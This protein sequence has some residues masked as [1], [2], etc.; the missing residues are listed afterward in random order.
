[1]ENQK[2]AK[3]KNLEDRLQNFFERAVTLCKKVPP[4]AL[5]QRIVSQLI[6]SSGSVPANFAEAS[7]A[8]SKKDF[9]K[10]VKICRKESKESRVWLTSILVKT[11]KK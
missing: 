9:I 4:S 8:M 1:M 10:C 6:G 3:I 7:E 2:T 11:D 5:T